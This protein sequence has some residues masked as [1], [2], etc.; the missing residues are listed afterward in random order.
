MFYFLAEKIFI[1]TL[2]KLVKQ[3]KLCN[4]WNKTERKEVSSVES[5]RDKSKLWFPK[6]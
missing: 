4:Q 5:V 3:G 6:L 2:F 1:Q